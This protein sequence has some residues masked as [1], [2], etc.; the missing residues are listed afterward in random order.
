M[1]MGMRISRAGLLTLLSI[2]FAASSHSSVEAMTRA[3]DQT[4]RRLPREKVRGLSRELKI[5]GEAKPDK[6]TRFMPDIPVISRP[7]PN[8]E[9]LSK[10][11][12]N[13]KPQK[14]APK[15]EPE[16]PEI[17]QAAT[18][19]VNKKNGNTAK[20]NKVGLG[21]TL[22]A[23]HNK[24]LVE[25]TGLEHFKEV[26]VEKYRRDIPTFSIQFIVE[27]SSNPPNLADYNELTDVSEEYLDNFFR[28]V[29]E[30]VK[31][32]H[33]ETALFLLPKENDP[34]TVEFKLTLEFVIPGEVPTINFLID[35]LQ[36]AFE[37]ETSQAF[38]I[39]DLSE[40]SETN[41]FSKTESFIVVSRPPVS[42]AEMDRT[43]GNSKGPGVEIVG[44]NYVLISVLAGM[45]CVVLVGTGLMWKRKKRGAVSDSNEAFSLF[46]KSNKKGKIAGIYGADEDTMNYL[47]SI[48]KRYKDNGKSS[49]SVTD[50]EN[51][52]VM[53][54]SG[55]YDHDTVDTT[56]VDEC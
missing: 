33:D 22:V 18:V 2:L 36:A 28:T 6:K 41:P 10:H 45:G 7:I 32:V 25:E 39:A 37:M 14:S 51:I 11:T 49:S 24:P 4:S 1:V 5:G 31:V 54:K 55:S 30:D 29:F 20:A 38:Y 42:A 48:R 47:N 17:K 35:R 3:N 19:K 15:S 23:K 53:G 52:A 43:G 50:D 12:I 26:E 34:Y 40:M 44:N 46:D 56:G 13:L 16:L 9:K 27:D 21:K 8:P